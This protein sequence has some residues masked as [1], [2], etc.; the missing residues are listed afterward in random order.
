MRVEAV[1]A[2]ARCLFGNC[3]GESTS[4]STPNIVSEYLAAFE[5]F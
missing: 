2:A 1:L 5:A 4:L 3:E